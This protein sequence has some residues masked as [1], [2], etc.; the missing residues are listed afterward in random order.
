MAKKN[1][2]LTLAKNRL[3]QK[4]GGFGM[5][6]KLTDALL[7]NLKYII[8]LKIFEDKEWKI[9]LNEGKVHKFPHHYNAAFPTYFPGIREEARL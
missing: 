1:C 6:H 7:I 3:D 2:G 9:N 4:Q 5:K 8:A